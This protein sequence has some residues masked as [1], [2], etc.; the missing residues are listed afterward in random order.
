MMIR[1]D[2]VNATLFRMAYAVDAGNAVIHRN[3]ERR[4]LFGAGNVNNRGREAVA[5]RNAIR[6]A[7]VDAR[8]AK[9]AQAAHRKR[10]PGR[11][12]G[13]V[14][15]HDADVLASG[16]RRQQPIDRVIEARQLLRSG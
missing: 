14:V 15:T 13:V 10:R 11:T 8:K 1:D 7:V 3:E 9:R 4:R 12:V 5:M 16:T 6:H 2:D